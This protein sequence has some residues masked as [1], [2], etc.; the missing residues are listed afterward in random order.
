MLRLKDI[1]MKPKLMG[2]LLLIGLIPMAIGGWWAGRLA[3]RSLME[4]SF[5]QLE[6]VRGIKAHQIEKFLAERKGD[7]GGLAETVGTLRTEAFS[8]LEAVQTIKKNQIETYFE[9]QLNLL[10]DVKYNLRFTEGIGPF[11]FAFQN[12]LNSSEYKA[13]GSEKEKGF[14]KFME[15][16][17]FYDL[18]L[19]W[20]PGSIPLQG[21]ANL[22][23]G[24]WRQEATAWQIS[25][26]MHRAM[27]NRV[28][29]SPSPSSMAER[30]S[31]LLPF[32]SP[33]MPLTPS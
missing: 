13:L 12:G 31:W 24:S 20:F 2:L 30:W 23:D 5:G 1:K 7:M 17:G 32:S 33:W 9:E 21:S 8:K 19:I 6:S 10:D 11:A 25:R 14:S 22:S 16:F 4:K 26:P 18:F 15:I 28:H 27:A 29:L 3:N